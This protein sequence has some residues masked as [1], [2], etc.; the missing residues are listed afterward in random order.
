MTCPTVIRVTTGTGPPGIGLPAGTGDAGKFVRKAG[1]T[2]YAY[3]LVTP[4]Q[5]GLPQGLSNTSSPTFAGLTLSGQASPV[6]RLVVVGAN[7]QL[8]SLAIGTNLAIVDGALVAAGGS[9]GSGGYPSLTMP[10]GFSVAGNTSASLVVTFATGYSL[11]NNTRQGLWDTAYSERLYW[12]GSS[13]GLNATTARASLALGSAATSATTDF[14]SAAQGALAATAVQPAALTA[15]LAGKADL[16]GGLVPTSQIPAIALVQYLGQAANQAAML[17]LRGQGGDW[18]IRTDS[19]TEWVIVAN[20]GAT[21]SDWIQLPNGISPVSSI[22]G[23]TGAVTLG[24]GDLGESGGN[25]FFTASRAIGSALTGF[26]AGAGTVA[27]TDSILQAINKIVGNIANRALTGLI[28]S[29][30]LT[31]NTNRLIGR[32]TAGTGAPEEI[33]T[34][35]GLVLVGGVLVPGEIVKLVVSNVGETGITTGNFK[36]ETRIDRA[37]VV[38]GVWWNCHPT[39][40]G[41]AATSDARPYIRTGAGT[42]SVGTKTNLLTTTNNVASL[43]ASVHTVDATSS[44]SG[45]TYSGSAGDWLGVD[46]MSLGTGSSGHM[47][48]YVLRYS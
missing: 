41:S 18:C 3:E 37:F 20:N 16:V 47:L 30:G 17:A 48:T 32:S 10:T 19:S 24:T 4:D 33:S 23:Q 29:S 1:T 8:V 11:P 5:V 15:G 25:L 26:V 14:A 13:T 35:G 6:V 42:T 22:N 34:S 28:G 38:V 31:M 43:A 9:G 45:G 2:A 36:S 44:I 21:L 39:A 7:G 40:M 46:F 27:A 12:D